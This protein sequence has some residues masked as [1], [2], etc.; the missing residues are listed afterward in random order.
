MLLSVGLLIARLVFRIPYWNI[1]LIYLFTTVYLL[2]IGIGLF[3][4][5]YTDTQQQAMFIAWFFTVIYSNEWIVYPHRNAE[6]G[7]TSDFVQSHPLFCG[8]NSDGNA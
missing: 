7:S 6:L 5:N 2:V 3:I 1:G 8:N 4:S